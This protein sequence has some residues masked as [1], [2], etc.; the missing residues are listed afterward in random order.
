MSSVGNELPKEMARVRD[1]LLP[2][3]DALPGGTGA[4]AAFLMRRA[5]DEAAVALAEGD[6]I[7][8]LRAYESLKGFTL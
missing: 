8:V 2:V 7:R 1:V 3:Y 5:L 4:P 6:V